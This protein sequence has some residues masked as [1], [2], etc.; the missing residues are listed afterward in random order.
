MASKDG[1]ISNPMRFSDN[2]D[3]DNDDNNIVVDEEATAAAVT[4]SLA[5]SIRLQL[6][7]I[8]QTKKE[9]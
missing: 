8:I 3:D 2:D 9:N 6:N 4:E 1:S 7:T 5:E